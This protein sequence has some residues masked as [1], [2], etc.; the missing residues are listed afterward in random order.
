MKLENYFEKI[1]TFVDHLFECS[2]KKFVSFQVDDPKDIEEFLREGEA[3]I[4][5]AC[6][7]KIPYP[8][9]VR[10]NWIFHLKSFLFR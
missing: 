9:P 3:R 5:L 1:S 2:R 8:R 4:E 10:I 6:H 7:Y